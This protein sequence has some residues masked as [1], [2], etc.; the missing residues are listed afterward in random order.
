LR[1]IAIL[2]RGDDSALVRADAGVN[3]NDLVHWTLGHGLE[4]LEISR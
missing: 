3:W 4:G 1:E 2:E